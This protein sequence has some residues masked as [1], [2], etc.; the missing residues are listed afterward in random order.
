[1]KVLS[2][3]FAIAFAA[4]LAVAQSADDPKATGAPGSSSSGSSTSGSSD[5][6]STSSAARQPEKK[7]AAE[8]VSAD[9]DSQ[10]I[11]VRQPAAKSSSGSAAGSAAGAAASASVTLPVEGKAVA[12]LKDVNSGE[13]VTLT[14]RQ[15]AS[16]SGSTSGSAGRDTAGGAMGSSPGSSTSGSTG[17]ASGSAG[18]MAASS[19][20]QDCR[21]VIEISKQKAS[22]PSTEQDS[23][24]PKY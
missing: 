2:T 3:L 18:S 24:S 8:V 22:S 20:Q 21:S 19:I 10:T 9:P 17:S 23:S 5:E 4:S 1:M 16:M 6:S 13:K 12:K 14:C 15:D 11:T 7:I